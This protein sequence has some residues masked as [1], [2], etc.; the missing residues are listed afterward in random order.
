MSTISKICSIEDCD[1]PVLAR[2]WCST[3]YSRWRK[4][5]H[6]NLVVRESH[7]CVLPDCEAPVVG[8]GLCQKHYMRRRRGKDP[9]ELVG[10]EVREGKRRCSRCRQEVPLDGFSNDKQSWCRE[11]AAQV[12]RDNYIPI[13]IPLPLVFCVECGT[14]YS[15]ARRT[16]ITCSTKCSE[17]R[18]TRFNRQGEMMRRAKLTASYIEHVESSIVFERDAWIC[19][20]CHEAIDPSLKWPDRLSATVDHI[21]P[22]NRGG[23]HSYS[24]CQA[25]HFACNAGKSDRFVG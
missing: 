11:C 22:L 8:N 3:H 4:N 18:R 1:N 20:L 21:T 6:T 9:A 12:A 25:A 7:V 10:R 16:N 13:V 5:G 14:K 23:D 2:S 15:P 17:Q 19:Q 24:N